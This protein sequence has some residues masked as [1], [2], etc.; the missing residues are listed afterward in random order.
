MSLVLHRGSAVFYF[1]RVW[2]IREFIASCCL[3]FLD[4]KLYVK[5]CRIYVIYS[6]LLHLELNF[7]SPKFSRFAK[8][9]RTPT[10]VFDRRFSKEISRSG[11]IHSLALLPLIEGLFLVFEI[12]S[13]H[14]FMASLLNFHF[15][16]KFASN[17]YQSHNNWSVT[18]IYGKLCGCLICFELRK[19]CSKV[20]I[21]KVTKISHLKAIQYEYDHIVWLFTDDCILFCRFLLDIW[22][23]FL[24]GSSHII[25]LS[26]KFVKREKFSLKL[27]DIWFL[28]CCIENMLIQ[29]WYNSVYLS[30]FLSILPSLVIM[31]DTMNFYN[32]TLTFYRM[33]LSL[34]L[35]I[36]Y[37]VLKTSMHQTCK[38]NL[39]T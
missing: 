2:P 13:I 27:L 32:D 18:N 14:Q 24:I 12:R 22:E 36:L 11:I 15:R 23:H 3:L 38:G 25:Y 19:Q 30:I 37:P 5:L 29:L 39:P 9:S 20:P 34:K 1:V 10:F 7:L 35:L 6:P 21:S 31:E 16:I 28:G 4:H 26:K 17:T 8:L 33:L